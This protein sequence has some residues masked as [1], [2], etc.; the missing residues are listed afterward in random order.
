EP[1]LLDHIPQLFDAILDRLEIDRPREDAEAFATVHGFTRR[2]SGYNVV[3]T[4]L[5]LLMFRRAI[6]SYLI[7]VGARVD[8]AYA[9]M[10]QIDGMVDR[11]VLSS[12]SAFLDPTARLLERRE[13]ADLEAGEQ[14]LV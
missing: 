6:W 2:I 7:A 10:E 9:A 12:L 3:E 8:G 14:P 4:V 11:A 1:L 5:E 13:E